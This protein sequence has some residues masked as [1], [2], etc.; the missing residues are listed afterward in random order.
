MKGINF[1]FYEYV[2]WNL[3]R[4]VLSVGRWGERDRASHMWLCSLLCFRC[5]FIRRFCSDKISRTNI[6]KWTH[7][8]QFCCCFYLE[9]IY[10][11]DCAQI[12][13]ATHRQKEKKKKTRSSRPDQKLTVFIHGIR[14]NSM[15]REKWSPN[16]FFNAC[17]NALF[18][19]ISNDHLTIHDH[20]DTKRKKKHCA[21]FLNAPQETIVSLRT[22]ECPSIYR[23]KPHM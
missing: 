21:S 11:L 12:R 1:H 4:L 7:F 14:V 17:D 9:M 15:E 6:F 13:A 22:Q 8:F 2:S 3:I 19:P 5:S 10:W 20:N 23:V 16:E 18:L